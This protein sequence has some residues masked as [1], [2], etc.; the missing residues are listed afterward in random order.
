MRC[1]RYSGS[2]FHAQEKSG[3]FFFFI[4]SRTVLT[5]NIRPV[6]E[7]TMFIRWKPPS[8][9]N[10]RFYKVFMQWKHDSGHA[11]M[12]EIYRGNSTSYTFTMNNMPFPHA[13]YVISYT[14]GFVQPV[15][16]TG[17]L[18]T[19]WSKSA[20]ISHS[21]FIIVSRSFS[22]P[23]RNLTVQSVSWGSA[24]VAW[25]PPIAK[26]PRD[27]V[28]RYHVTVE[29]RGIKV[30]LTTLSTRV[31]V[32]GLKQMTSYRVNVQAGNEVGYGPFLTDGVLFNTVG[33]Y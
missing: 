5:V 24:V 14:E 28:N 1:D 29:S 15:P 33:K 11:K 16:L 30:E 4:D 9:P 17:V 12:I 32:A 18:R 21:W 26:S 25:Q 6:R 3:F 13:F 27:L 10:T 8:D 2:Y 23:P 20:S 7:K 31:T 22:V 19:P